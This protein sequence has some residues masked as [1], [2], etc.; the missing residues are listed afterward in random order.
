MVDGTH[1]HGKYRGNLMIASAQDANK[2]IYPLAFAVVDSENDQSW[3]FFFEQLSIVIPNTP[4]LVFI[5]DRHKSIA[6]AI[7]RVYSE[8]NHVVCTRH[9]KE[10]LKTQFKKKGIHG[11]FTLASNS[12]TKSEFEGFFKK[13]CEMDAKMGDYLLRANFEKWSRSHFKG[14]TIVIILILTTM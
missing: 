10:N 13:N 9:L 5:S 8:E 1:L 11:L 4:N 3:N 12:Y 14:T 7:Q 6:K 2:Q